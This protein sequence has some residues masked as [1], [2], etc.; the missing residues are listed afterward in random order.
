MRKD[1][2]D[3]CGDE[4]DWFSTSVTIKPGLFRSLKDFLL[5][6]RCDAELFKRVAAFLEEDF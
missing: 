3:R 1:F 2:C 6:K 5:C 4:T